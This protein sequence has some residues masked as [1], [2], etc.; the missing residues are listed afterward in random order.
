MSSPAEG[1]EVQREAK[2]RLMREAGQLRSHLYPL[3]SDE[4]WRRERLYR[5]LYW[6]EHR[7]HAPS[8]L[9]GAWEVPDL[10]REIAR[11]NDY[12]RRE[13]D[14]DAVLELLDRDLSEHYGKSWEAAL[15]E[16]TSPLLAAVHMPIWHA[17][18]G[19]LIPQALGRLQLFNAERYDD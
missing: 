3:A 16:G 7:E 19:S 1:M 17:A 18:T 4:A 15:E 11:W 13:L 10:E 14:E 12:A 2:R 8:N 6:R 9:V 5:Y